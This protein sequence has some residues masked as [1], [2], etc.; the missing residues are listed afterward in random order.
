[1]TT[2]SE[3]Q[4]VIAEVIGKHRL[5]NGMRI[6]RGERV[7]WWECLECGWRSEEFDLDDSE[8]RREIER[9]KLAHV[10]FEVDKALGGLTREEQWVPVEESGHRWRGRS[11]DEAAWALANFSKNGD[12]HDPDTDSPLTHVEHEA[13]WVSG[14]SEA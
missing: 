8:V 1:M 5:E 10:A 9:V 11:E 6:G 12:F 7:E 3:A 13:R 14:W 4:N 2:P